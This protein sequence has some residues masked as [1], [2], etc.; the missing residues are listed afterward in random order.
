MGEALPPEQILALV[1]ALPF[2]GSLDT[3]RVEPV[4]MKVHL[5]LLAQ[6]TG[7]KAKRVRI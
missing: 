7:G 2:G 4:D 3:S 1:P 5:H 6:M